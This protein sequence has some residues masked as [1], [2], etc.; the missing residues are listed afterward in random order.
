ME[1]H[2]QKKRE[3]FEKLLSLVKC[4]GPGT[5][6]IE[7]AKVL[8]VGEYLTQPEVAVI[9][10]GAGKIWAIPEDRNYDKLQRNRLESR[11]DVKKGMKLRVVVVEE[12]G[13][14]DITEV[15]ILK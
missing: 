2:I 5:Y 9:E 3:E 13:E 11:W 7:V 10:D 8:G 12:D 1:K 14:K 15:I 6:D 4:P